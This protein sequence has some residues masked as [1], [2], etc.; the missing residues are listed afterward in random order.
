M[1]R[2]TFETYCFIESVFLKHVLE[3]RTIIFRGVAL[4]IAPS[5]FPRLNFVLLEG[6]EMLETDVLLL[7]IE[8]A[9]G[10]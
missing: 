9:S 1:S 5:A 6:F 8:E 10:R 3:C 2:L 4:D 7:R